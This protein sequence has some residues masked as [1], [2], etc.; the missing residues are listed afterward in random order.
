MA[1]PD[2]RVPKAWLERLAAVE[3]QLLRRE[4]WQLEWDRAWA[5]LRGELTE[6][7]QPEWAEGVQRRVGVDT[8]MAEQLREDTERLGHQVQ[9]D[10]QATEAIATQVESCLA[11]LKG[12]QEVLDPRVE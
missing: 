12:L 10:G 2:A 9:L 8:R 11:L 4:N 1:N 7:G 3:A 5:D 6:R